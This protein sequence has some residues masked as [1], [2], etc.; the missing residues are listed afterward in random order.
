MRNPYFCDVYVS[1][2][3]NNF[4]LF[5]IVPYSLALDTSLKSNSSLSIHNSSHFVP[6]ISALESVCA[7]PVSSYPTFSSD[8]YGSLP[9]FRPSVTLLLLDSPQHSLSQQSSSDLSAAHYSK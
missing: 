6:T 9:V 1:Y 7:Q 4:Q 5:Y 2:Q 3:S 8:N